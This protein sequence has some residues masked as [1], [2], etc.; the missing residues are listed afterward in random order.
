[1]TT[2]DP[3]AASHVAIDVADG[4]LRIRLQRP[5]RKNALTLAMYAAMADA[6]EGAAG[7]DDVRAI[8]IAGTPGCFTSGNDIGDFIRAQQGGGLEPVMRFLRAISAADKPIVAAV[9]G[10]AIGI[11]TTLLLHCDLVYASEAARF[12]TPFVDL[13]L[14][15]EAGSSVLLPALLGYPRAAAMILLG[16]ELSARTA[17]DAGLINEI[18]P[19]AELDGRV[20]AVCARLA[21]RAPAALR[22]S[23]ALLKRGRKAAA[24]EAMVEEARQFLARLATPEAAEAMQAFMQRRPADFSKFH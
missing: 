9:D 12:K 14:V 18:V 16:E 22:A 20:A 17:L 2:S 6:L 23:K 1:M 19:S 15:P 24:D 8:S 4:V 13:G 5:E 10:V 21:S 7:R 11:G 3:A